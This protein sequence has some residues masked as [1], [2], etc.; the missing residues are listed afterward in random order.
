MATI[1]ELLIEKDFEELK[2]F[3]AAAP[4]Y[5]EAL[6]RF[7]YLENLSELGLFEAYRAALL[8][9]KEKSFPGDFT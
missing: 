3:D 6:L 2:K 4:T 7:G 5:T 8:H 9:D 1:S